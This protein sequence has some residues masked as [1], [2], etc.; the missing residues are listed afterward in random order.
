MLSLVVRGLAILFVA[1]ALF[2]VD[3]AAA[4]STSAPPAQEDCRVVRKFKGN[5]SIETQICRGAD[6]VFREIERTPGAS[7]ATFRG[8]IFY[9]GP[10]SGWVETQQRRSPGL[11]TSIFSGGPKKTDIDGEASLRLDFSGNTV[12]GQLDGSG[13]RRF[14][15]TFTGVVRD[16]KCELTDQRTGIQ[17]NGD[18]SADGFTGVISVERSGNRLG[19]RFVFNLEASRL[20]DLDERE[21]DRAVEREERTNRIAA[22]RDRENELIA[23]LVREAE[24]GDVESMR[25]LAAIYGGQ[26]DLKYV[27]RDYAKRARWLS[28]AA[29]K[30]D[31]QSIYLL[32]E[33][34]REAKGVR[35]DYSQAFGLFSR[36][37]QGKSD[38]TGAC[39][40][41]LG[42]A[43]YYGQGV[44]Q[45]EARSI[46][47]FRRCANLGVEP[48]QSNLRKLTS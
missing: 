19:S 29:G 8:Q 38:F 32:A 48:C 45:S 2:L 47:Q 10:Y 31:Q 37:S 23:Q 33:A 9:Q 7:G 26:T 16:G 39:I 13:G 35:R 36:C 17:L 41:H 43:Y 14:R 1:P 24:S 3:V 6:G 30:N 28:M 34:Y 4:Q 11:L 18:C 5:Q 25:S 22:E 42:L 21:F 12:K 20:V 46:E 15:Y 40:F 27:R 44:A